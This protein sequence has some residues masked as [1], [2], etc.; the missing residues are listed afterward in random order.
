MK[1]I[2]ESELCCTFKALQACV[3][4]QAGMYFKLHLQGLTGIE[5]KVT[6]VLYS[7]VDSFDWHAGRKTK[8]TLKFYQK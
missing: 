6:F 1:E 4:V 5:N 8:V 3:H 2:Q 7:S